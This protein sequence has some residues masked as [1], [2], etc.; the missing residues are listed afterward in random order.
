MRGS[1]LNFLAF[2]LIGRSH[3]MSQDYTVGQ[4]LGDYEILGIL[5][6]GGMGKVYKVRNTISDRVEA[7]KILLPDLAGQKDLAD[8]FLREIKVLAS[9]NHPNIASLRTALT[10]DNQLVMIMEFV[11][12]ITISSRL[13]DGAIPP[14]LAIKYIDQ[15]LDALS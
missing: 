5:G 14:A 4:K 15:I 10:M 1:P 2:F 13:R 3:N 6:A 8:R 7:M 11:D 9:L 12:G